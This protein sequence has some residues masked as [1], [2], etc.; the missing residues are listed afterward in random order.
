VTGK[1]Q[2]PRRAARATCELIMDFQDTTQ[3]ATFRNEVRDFI[4]SECPAGIRRRGL[5]AMFGGGGWDDIR[6]GTDDY[7]KLNAE[8]AKKLADRGWTAPAWP[9]EYG[10][11]GRTVMA[12]FLFKRAMATPGRP[13]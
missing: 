6:M 8:W 11:A 12:P 5:G 1:L 9:K 2:E 3:E 4:G 7:R 13:K 10:S